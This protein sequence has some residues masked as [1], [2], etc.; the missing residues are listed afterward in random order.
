MKIC[1]A[2]VCSGQIKGSISFKTKE[3]KSKESES[4]RHF[5]DRDKVFSYKILTSQVLMHIQVC[6]GAFIA[7]VMRT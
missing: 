7:R 2:L 6:I 4:K 5:T 1:I 3:K